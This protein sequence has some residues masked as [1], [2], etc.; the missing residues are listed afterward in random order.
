MRRPFVD[1]VGCFVARSPLPCVSTMNLVGGYGSSSSDDDESKEHEQQQAQ[2]T[3]DVA[4]KGK[5]KAVLP[6]RATVGVKQPT[7]GD[8]SMGKRKSSSTKKKKKK[9]NKVAASS[10]MKKKSKTVNALVL[11]PEIQAALAR[12]DTLGDSDSDEDGPKKPPKIVRRPAGSNPNDLLSLLPQPSTAASAD[13]I[14]LKNKKRREEAKTAAKADA[15]AEAQPAASSSAAVPAPTSTAA[16]ATAAGVGKVVEDEESDSDDDQDDLLAG[17]HAKAAAA[18]ASGSDS[19]AAAI[20]APLFTLPSRAKQPPAAVAAVAAGSHLP[21]EGAEVAGVTQPLVGDTAVGAQHHVVAHQWGAADTCSQGGIGG[22]GYSGG[23]GAGAS[24]QYVAYGD[25]SGQVCLQAG[26]K[27][28][29]AGGGK[30]LLEPS[31]YCTNYGLGG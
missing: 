8:T 15:A 12:G 16:P 6:A 30:A 1:K 13:D 23:A 22:A 29:K 11:S 17:M 25:T 26:F 14:L 24:T 31:I 10:K 3:L 7:A 9:K 27:I 5:G 19:G 20:S 18:A 28:G 2:P 21:D 4:P